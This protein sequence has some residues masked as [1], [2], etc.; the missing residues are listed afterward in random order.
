MKLA[1]CPRA[2]RLNCCV[3]QEQEIFRI[4][5]ARPRIDVHHCFQQ[6]GSK[7]MVDTGQFR[8]DLIV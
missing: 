4:G 7:K 5:E 2:C 3:I 8:A 6:Q 1:R